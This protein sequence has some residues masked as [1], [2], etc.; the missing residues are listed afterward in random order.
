M[1]RDSTNPKTTKTRVLFACVGNTCRSVMAEFIAR[2]R[3]GRFFEP[4]SAGIRPQQP[5]DAGN[6]VYTLKMVLNIEASGH[7]PRDI[8]QVDVMSFDLVVA[9]DKAVADKFVGEFRTFPAE[10]LV[11][12][13][14]DDPYGDDLRRYEHCAQAI[15]GELK[16]LVKTVG[17]A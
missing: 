2:E 14:I 6:A 9:M 17:P 11:R 16:A 1:V 15:F 4:S 5:A 10:R 13:N 12:W 7:V 3:F 8:R